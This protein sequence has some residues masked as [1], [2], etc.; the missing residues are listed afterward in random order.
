MLN[1]KVKIVVT[2]IPIDHRHLEEYNKRHSEIALALAKE[3]G[4]I[5][6][7]LNEDRIARIAANPEPYAQKILIEPGLMSHRRRTATNLNKLFSYFL[8]MR[9]RLNI[10]IIILVGDYDWLDMRVKRL[11]DVVERLNYDDY[12][13]WG[14]SNVK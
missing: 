4:D 5:A 13:R 11:W 3:I 9:R 7:I 2:G 10:G 8:S 14:V 12:A 1:D 6:I